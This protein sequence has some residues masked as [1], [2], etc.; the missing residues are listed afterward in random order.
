MFPEIF[1]GTR[2]SKQNLECLSNLP[3]GS[4]NHNGLPKFP[5]EV[6]SLFGHI[7]ILYDL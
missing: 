5:I 7:N 6:Y 2:L 4:E 1:S 3:I